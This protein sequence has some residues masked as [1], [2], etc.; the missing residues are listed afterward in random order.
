MG[1][2]AFLEASLKRVYSSIEASLLRVNS[3]VEASLEGT[4]RLDGV[5]RHLASNDAREF[6]ELRLHN[7]DDDAP[8][9]RA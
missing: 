2:H 6:L 5:L 9:V 3:L 4:D 1:L 8:I 7:R